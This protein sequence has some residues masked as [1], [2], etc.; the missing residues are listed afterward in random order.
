MKKTITK[1]TIIGVVLGGISPALFQYLDENLI[2]IKHNFSINFGLIGFFMSF[3][4]T[5]LVV[6]DR[7]KAMSIILVILSF[8]LSGISYGC[9]LDLRFHTDQNLSSFPLEILAI[10]ISISVFVYIFSI[11]FMALGKNT[12]SAIFLTILF[13]L[14]VLLV[15]APKLYLFSLPSYLVFVTFINLAIN[16]LGKRKL[17]NILGN[18]VMIFIVYSIILIVN[19]YFSIST[20]KFSR[21]AVI[22]AIGL[23]CCFLPLIGVFLYLIELSSKNK[24]SKTEATFDLKWVLSSASLLSNYIIITSPI[25][26]LNYVRS[27]NLFEEMGIL[28]TN[29]KQVARYLSIATLIIQLIFMVYT[30]FSPNIPSFVI[31]GVATGVASFTL[32]YCFTLPNENSSI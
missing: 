24:L 8:S 6:L 27:A 13:S 12:N 2:E 32:S 25:S 23:G 16:H 5:P 15:S 18:L 26:L 30:K 21:N 22:F 28:K 20:E 7:N 19:F 9:L 11:C 14:P 29:Q 10:P 1:L 3:F 17:P 4:F 31:W